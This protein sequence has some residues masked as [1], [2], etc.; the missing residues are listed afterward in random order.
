MKSDERNG[1][2]LDR[3]DGHGNDTS[4][5]EKIED[6]PIVAPSPVSFALSPLCGPHNRTGS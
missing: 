5:L 6:V 2:S 3:L 1:V 4:E